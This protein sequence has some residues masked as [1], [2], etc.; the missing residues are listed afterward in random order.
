MAMQCGIV[1]L[2]NVGKSTI[3]NALTKSH[4][5]QSAN[6]PFCTIDPNLGIVKIPD[7]RFEKICEFVHPK[8]TVPA[9]VEFLDIAGLVKGASKGEGLG[10]A[11]LNHIRQ[12]QAILHVVRC[13]EDEN[14]IHVSG[15]V[16]PL[17]DV[18]TI[19]LELILADL[20]QVE[21]KINSIQRLVKAGDKSA[22]SLNAVL[23]KVKTALSNSLPANSLEL[24]ED[25]ELAIREMA[26]LTLKPVLFAGNLNEEFIS[27]PEQSPHFSKLQEIAQK[28]GTFAIPLCGKVEEELCGLPPEEEM[29]FL[30]EFGLKEAGLNRVIREA[31]K[32][33]GYITFFTAGVQEVRAWNIVQGTNAQDAAGKIHSDIQRGFI[34]AETTSYDDFIQYGGL[35]EAQAA[36]KMR[37]EGKEY[38]VVD[39]DIIYFRFNV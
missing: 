10:N 17:E 13:F 25:E 1:G 35:K 11:F 38:T 15:S 24:S 29:V 14:V 31:Y 22:V 39:G 34:R 12:V 4:S 30:S 20:E 32:L 16:N 19:E 37:L 2:P 7:E 28:R 3:F 36:G 33:L 5:A 18:E 21:K 8:S 23:E 26:L 9:T 6:F 27:K